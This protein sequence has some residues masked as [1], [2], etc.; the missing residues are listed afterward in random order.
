MT[1]TNEV[2]IHDELRSD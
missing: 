2:C 1:V